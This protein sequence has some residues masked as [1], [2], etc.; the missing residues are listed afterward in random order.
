MA[1]TN[2]YRLYIFVRTSLASMTRGKIA[3]QTAHAGNRFTDTFESKR[4]FRRDVI[5]HP[6]LFSPPPDNDLVD[7]Y[8][9]WKCSTPQSFGTTIVL[10][11]NDLSLLKLS[12][13][14]PEKTPLYNSLRFQYPYYF[15]IITDPEYSIVDGTERLTINNVDTCCIL[16]CS[17]EDYTTFNIISSTGIFPKYERYKLLA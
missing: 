5:N 3:A 13:L 2:P 17:V 12:F 8:V 7:S 15:E 14:D 11:G 16:F 9:I 10:D 1:V 6:K 4:S